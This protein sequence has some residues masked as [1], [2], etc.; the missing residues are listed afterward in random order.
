MDH[1]SFFPFHNRHI[2]FL[3]DGVPKK[4]VVIDSIPYDKKKF[5]TEY[6]YISTKNMRAWKDAEKTHDKSAMQ[7]LEEKINL[8][9]ITEPSL[10]N[11]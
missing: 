3:Y 10:I 1:L 8:L 2:K 5:S 6:I 7:A 9:K 4:G 11:H